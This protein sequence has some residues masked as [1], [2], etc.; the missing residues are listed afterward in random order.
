MFGDEI[1]QHSRIVEVL[2]RRHDWECQHAAGIVI[3]EQPL[4]EY[5]AIDIRT[6]AVMCDK[7]DAETLNL[8]K[9]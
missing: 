7:K 5:V 1:V 3:T 2:D 6:N 9:T 8:L 4:A